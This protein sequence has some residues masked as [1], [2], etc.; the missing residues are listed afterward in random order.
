M[1]YKKGNNGDWTVG[2]RIILPTNEELTENNTENN[3]GWVWHDEPPQEYLIWK[4][5]ND[6]I[7]E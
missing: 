4:D 1:F 2:I 3:Y 5:E 7:R 6:N